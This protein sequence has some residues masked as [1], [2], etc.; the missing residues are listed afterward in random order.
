MSSANQFCYHLDIALLPDVSVL[1]RLQITYTNLST[2][3]SNLLELTAADR[4]KAL[5]NA[6]AL[7]NITI[8]YQEAFY[9]APHLNTKIHID[10]A[11]KHNNAKINYIYGGKGSQMAWYKP[12]NPDLNAAVHITPKGHRVASWKPDECQLLY[13]SKLSSPSL[14]NV[15]IPHNVL[16]TSDEGRWCLSYLLHDASTNTVLQW[17]DAVQRLEPW[18]TQN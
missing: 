15:G 10:G 2:E 14:V 9:T 4:P 13:Q 12:M 18:L 17:E 7:K 11:N 5:L 8:G 6:L 1:E 3:Y 16:N